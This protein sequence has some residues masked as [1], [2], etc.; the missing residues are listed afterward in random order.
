MKWKTGCFVA[1]GR[2]G[3]EYEIAVYMDVAQ[4]S[5]AEHS[6]PESREQRELRTSGGL[7][8][9]RLSKGVYEVVDIG[10]ILMSH[11]PTAP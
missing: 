7:Y 2:S 3:Q 4:E 1:T 6:D 11:A 8:V 9:T 10:E 5:D